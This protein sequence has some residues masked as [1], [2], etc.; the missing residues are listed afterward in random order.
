MIGDKTSDIGAGLKSNLKTVLVKTGYG[1]KDME[2][3]DKNE[4][5]VCE[6]L[7]DFSEILKR[8]KLNDL[9]F[10][11]FSKKVQIKNVVIG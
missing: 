3:I 1:L 11:E 8:E 9:L 10:E 7:K 5:L 4:T 2:K 6:N